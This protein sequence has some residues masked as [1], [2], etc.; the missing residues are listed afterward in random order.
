MIHALNI[1]NRHLKSNLVV[2]LTVVTPTDRPKLVRNHSVIDMFCGV[3][4][5]YWFVLVDMV[6]C[7]RH[8]TGS[9]VFLFLFQFP[10]RERSESDGDHLYLSYHF[11]SFR[12]PMWCERWRGRELWISWYNRISLWEERLLLQRKTKRTLVFLQ[13]S[14]NCTLSLS[15]LF[16]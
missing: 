3:F 7:K 4:L 6:A 5:Y 16:L 8:V 1:T 10:L 12:P 14:S 11:G 2:S 15:I 13:R 9:E